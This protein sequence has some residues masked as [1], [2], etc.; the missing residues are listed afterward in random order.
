MVYDGYD[1]KTILEAA[2][3]DQLVSGSFLIACGGNTWEVLVDVFP[4]IHALLGDPYPIW[5]AGLWNMLAAGRDM[6]TEALAGL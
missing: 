5:T 4:L 1:N 6:T 3:N 2:S